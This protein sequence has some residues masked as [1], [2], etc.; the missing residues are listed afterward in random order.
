MNKKGV[1]VQDQA[2]YKRL[3]IHYTLSLVTCYSIVHYIFFLNSV[4]CTTILLFS[5]IIGWSFTFPYG[6]YLLITAQWLFLCCS[7]IKKH[8][9][10]L[11]SA[12]E[13]LWAFFNQVALYR[14]LI[15]STNSQQ[16][17]VQLNYNVITMP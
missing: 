13:G 8:Y 5:G 6:C 14:N 16:S 1:L 9:N 11:T 15:R 7:C 17:V 10:I 2:L 3:R 12:L 4:G